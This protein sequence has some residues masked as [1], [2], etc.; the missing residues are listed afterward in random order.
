MLEQAQH[1]MS[2][3]VLHRRTFLKAAAATA[4]CF[5][6]LTLP[7]RLFARGQ[8]QTQPAL[9]VRSQDPVNLEF[10]FSAHESFITPNELFYVRSH[11]AVPQIN[12]NEWR[13]R[14]AGAV[15]QELTLSLADLR[16]LPSRTVTATLECAGN[17]RGLVRPELRGVGWEL[18]AVSNA[19]WTGVPLAALLDRAGVRDAAVD[20]ILEGT[21]R[22]N[23][24]AE[25]GL[26]EIHFSRSIPVAKARQQDVLLAYRMNGADL[27]ANH[28]FPL[29]AVVADWYGVA[30]IKWLQRISVS[31]RPFTGY[32]QTIDYT[33]FERRNGQP[34]MTPITE[35]QVKALI[36][37][38][39]ASQTVG[40]NAEVRVHGAAW[41]GDA[42]IARVEVSTNGGRTWQEARL[43]G[44]PAPHAWRLWEFS[45][46]TPAQAGAVTLMARA[47]DSRNRQQPMERD[48]DRRNYMVNHV[49]PVQVEV[50]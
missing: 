5:P 32:F 34:Q 47:T 42:A 2:Q 35:M 18:G 29:R 43:L 41:T 10:P 12:G 8:T 24:A 49:L 22:G 46:R 11:F 9:I 27:P 48:R 36:S 31:D 26:G 44:Q 39:T 3:H 38:P 20:V 14:V 21:D 50:R 1:S 40:T 37:Q 13:L 28:G 15:N 45:W 25:P 30:S 33:I 23:I 19:E 4:V 16:A 6:S 7:A 17:S